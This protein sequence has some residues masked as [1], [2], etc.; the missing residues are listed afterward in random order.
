MTTTDQ[1]LNIRVKTAKS[2]LQ[3]E[4]VLKLHPYLKMTFDQLMEK[5]DIEQSDFEDYM[6]MIDF[7]KFGLKM[8]NYDKV[9]KWLDALD[10]A[11]EWKIMM[12]T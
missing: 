9:G 3:K 2:M 10:F 11:Y 4:D 12:D 1:I 5:N 8:R 6:Y 7:I